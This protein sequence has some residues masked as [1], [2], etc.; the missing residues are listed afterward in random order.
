MRKNSEI[1]DELIGRLV[2]GTLSEED[3]VTIDEWASKSD[4]NRSV[5]KDIIQIRDDYKL[6]VQM[7]QINARKALTEVKKRIKSTGRFEFRTLLKQTIN[8]WQ[9]V[10]AV[11]IIPLLAFS[12]YMYFG[13]ETE[14]KL[15]WNE[16]STPYG[17]MSKI[18]LPDSTIVEINSRS[19]LRYPSTFEGKERLVELEGEAFFKVKQNKKTPFVVRCNNIDIQAV[20]TSFNVLEFKTGDVITSLVEGKV[21]LLKREGQTEQVIAVMQPGQTVRYNSNENRIVVD[22]NGDTDKYTAWREGK[23]IFRNDPLPDVLEQLSRRYNVDFE[24]KDRLNDQYAYT[25]TFVGKSL[26][27][28]LNYIELT[29]PIVFTSNPEKKD[30]RTII[31]VESRE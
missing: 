11:I 1:P 28:I 14:N 8:I 10:A 6:L 25:G 23:L 3:R 2:S 20:G 7:E 9:K 31:S 16:V 29:T 26:D 5:L 17:L 22:E 4:E 15:I 27:K 19:K 18:T 24:L 12:L 13:T 30:V 21:N